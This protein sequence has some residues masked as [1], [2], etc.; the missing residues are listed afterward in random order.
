M[1][2]LLIRGRGT[3]AVLIIG[4]D[5]RL[6]PFPVYEYKLKYQKFIQFFNFSITNEVDESDSSF[7]FR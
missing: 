1:L 5:P 7:R 3:V 2:T 6:V 4:V